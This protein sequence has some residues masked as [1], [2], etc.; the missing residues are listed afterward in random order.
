MLCQVRSGRR[1]GVKQAW[2]KHFA[3]AY[4]QAKKNQRERKGAGHN[5]KC[6]KSKGKGK[7]QATMYVCVCV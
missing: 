2:T 5:G 4:E 3:L 6:L 1:P 7:G